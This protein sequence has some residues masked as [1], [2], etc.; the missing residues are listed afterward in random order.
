MTQPAQE[1]AL[2]DQHRGFDLCLVARPARP[3]R[4]DRRV[5]M[6][7]H[8]GVAAIDL[9]FVK[10]GLDDRDFGIVR[11]QQPGH[12]ADGG[13]GSRVGSDPIAEPLRPVRFGIGEVGGPEHGDKNLRRP[14]LAIEPIDDH[15]HRVTGVI[16]KQLVAAAVG[17]PHR[18]RQPQRP[19]AVQFAEAGI[20]IPVRTVLD[21]LVPQD[22]QRN[23]LALQLAVNLGPIRF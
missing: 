17:L 15:R 22:L 2:D 13:K 20:A 8:L 7:R 1:P 21:V 12:A 23:V 5:V 3:C 6:R 10:A 4:Q 19:A 16:D 14:G 11:H 18:Q 9:R